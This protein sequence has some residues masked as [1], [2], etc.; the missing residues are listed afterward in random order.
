[1][2]SSMFIQERDDGFDVVLLDDVQNLRAF[3]QNAVQHLENALINERRRINEDNRSN[4]QMRI[5]KVGK[6]HTHYL[7]RSTDIFQC[8][9]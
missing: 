5:T 6:L 1:M 2:V 4:S 7:F 9:H 8:L 3:N